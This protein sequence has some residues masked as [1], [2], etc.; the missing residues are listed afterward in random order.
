MRIPSFFGNI[1]MCEQW[2]MNT[3]V[4]PQN[5]ISYSLKRGESQLFEFKKFE[6]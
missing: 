1:L 4:I 6:H 2:D 3:Y 5:D